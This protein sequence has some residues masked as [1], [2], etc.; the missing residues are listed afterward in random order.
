MYV[1]NQGAIFTKA[2]SAE[3]CRCEQRGHT[4]YSGYGPT[5]PIIL[6]SIYSIVSRQQLGFLLVTLSPYMGLPSST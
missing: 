1:H 5:C 4:V 6:C 2:Q 3:V